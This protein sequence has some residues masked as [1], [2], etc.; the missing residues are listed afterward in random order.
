MS[1]AI[2]PSTE[3]SFGFAMRCLF[4]LLSWLVLSSLFNW[5]LATANVFGLLSQ[6]NFA[7]FLRS[8]LR[9]VVDCVLLSAA[10]LATPSAWQIIKEQN[11]LSKALMWALVSLGSYLSTLVFCWGSPYGTLGPS[12]FTI[13]VPMTFLATVLW[14]RKVGATPKSLS[15]A[16]GLLLITNLATY[17]FCI[18]SLDQVVHT[19]LN[20]TNQL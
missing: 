13:S 19:Y 16:L 3:S 8:D 7:A 4:A 14:V 17:L 11:T 20:I 2:S 18:H 1:E 9:L 15:V 12:V 10:F 5:L 6:D